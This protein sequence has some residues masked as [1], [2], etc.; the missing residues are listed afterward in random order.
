MF[1][2]LRHG[3]WLRALVASVVAATGC[4]TSGGARPSAFPTAPVPAAVLRVPTPP[5]A[6]M[7][8]RS[9]VIRTALELRG[10]PYRLGGESPATGF[11][12]SGFVRYVFNLNHL[13]LPRTV[14]EQYALGTKI[15]AGDVRAGDLLFFST[16]APGASHVGIAVGGGEFVHAPAAKGV[17][18]VEHLETPYWR[19]RFVGAKRF[20]IP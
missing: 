16:T 6:V 5:A 11:D 18:R 2:H 3:R 8:G 15:R 4:A 12:C 10:V 1:L 14:S 13:A 19:E 20:L 17:V 9:N 7:P